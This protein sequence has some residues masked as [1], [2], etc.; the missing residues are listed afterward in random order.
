MGYGAETL[1]M[2]EANILHRGIR[3]TQRPQHL[4]QGANKRKLGK[5]GRDSADMTAFVWTDGRQG[6]GWGGACARGGVGPCRH[7]NEKG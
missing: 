5:G 1:A 3:D 2:R 4:K 6:Q 7:T